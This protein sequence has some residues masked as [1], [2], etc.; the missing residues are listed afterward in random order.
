MKYKIKLYAANALT[1]NMSSSKQLKTPYGRLMSSLWLGKTLI[2]IKS[3]KS[4]LSW[5]VHLNV[6]IYLRQSET[7]WIPLVDLVN[8]SILTA[9]H[10]K[11]K[12]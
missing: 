2:D 5:L 7:W 12:S 6:A 1:E 4:V 10:C 8:W 3:L 9:T 11:T